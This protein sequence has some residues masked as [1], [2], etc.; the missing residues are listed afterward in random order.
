MENLNRDQRDTVCKACTLEP[1]TYSNHA[2]AA[3]PGE[4]LAHLVNSLYHAHYETI[5]AS[6]SDS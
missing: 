4:D 5:C 3:L 6:E 2:H 1:C